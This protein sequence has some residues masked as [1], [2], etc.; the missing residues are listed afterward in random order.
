MNPVAAV[1]N[2]LRGPGRHRPGALPAPVD[3]SPVLLDEQVLTAAIADGDIEA[4]EFAFCGA[5]QRET[6]HA[7]H[8]DGS[9][10]CWTCQNVT[11]SE[12]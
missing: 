1:R 12:Q 8:S 11:G 5:E 2:L 7:I 10:T 4:N 6:F 9:R 3:E